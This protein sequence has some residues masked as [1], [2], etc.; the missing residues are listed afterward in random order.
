MTVI[1][2][3]SLYPVQGF[4]H[5]FY[6]GNRYHCLSAKVTLEWDAEGRLAPVERQPDMVLN[7][8]WLDE[9]NRSSLLYPSDLIP[10]K[11]TTDVLVVGTAR[12][13]EDRPM[14]TWYAALRVGGLEKRLRFHGPRQWRYTLLGGWALS[15]AEPVSG[16]A[17]LYENAY[18]GTLGP[19][20]AHYEDGEFFA[21]NP[22]GQGF[23][24]RSR[25]DT[26]QAY[27]APQIEAWDAPLG[28]FGQDVE[29]GGFG[30]LP[31]F[32]PARQRYAGTYDE[33]W[34]QTVAPDIPL[35]MDMRYWNT[36]PADQQPPTYLKAGDTIELAGVRPGPPL[37]LV[38]PPLDAAGVAHW[39]DDSRETHPVNLD[40]VL[41]DLDRERVTLRYHGLVDFDARIKRINVYCASTTYPAG[42]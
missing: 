36:A 38:L 14:P 11:P 40:T 33:H 15:E 24:D 27:P 2:S 29:P 42:S 13:P 3:Q 32:M 17:L 26:S 18:G 21:P 8:V 23:V 31:G 16:V 37:R 39:D 7:D 41:I 9:E 10:F 22:L 34:R 28:A 35:D 1:V 5:R 30:P 20:R 19:A 25:L 6:H 12:P 4:E